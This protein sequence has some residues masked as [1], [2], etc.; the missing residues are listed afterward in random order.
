L[1]PRPSMRSTSSS[2]ARSPTRT[3]ADS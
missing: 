1:H 2:A 3:A